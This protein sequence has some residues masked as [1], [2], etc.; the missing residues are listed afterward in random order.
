M[1]WHFGRKVR[2]VLR[3]L[4]QAYGTRRVKRLL[5]NT[6]FSRGRWDGLDRSPGDCVYPYVEKYAN[7][8]SILDL[9]CGSGSTGNELAATA[10]REYTGVDISDV[11]LAKARRRSAEDGRANKNSYLQAD[12]SSYVPAQQFDVIL[13]R[14]SI[15]YIPRKKI[16]PLLDRYSKYLNQKG[17]FI[18]RMFNTSGKYKRIMDILLN[19]F[20]VVEKYSPDESSPA[21]MVLRQKCYL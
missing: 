3:G 17:V 7:Q 13:F 16:K 14:D 6:E 2:N 5:W 11:A 18:V 8:G 19:N 12:I 1:S 21:V 20:E 9:G 10:Y 15:Y 4:L